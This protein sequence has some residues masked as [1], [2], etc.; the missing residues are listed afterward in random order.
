MS[1]KIREYPLN[2]FD[3]ATF[4]LY[5][6]V[7]KDAKMRA[8]SYKC[9]DKRTEKEKYQDSVNKQYIFQF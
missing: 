6:L 1:V 2:K 9:R 7:K 4:A 8:S 5:E 3:S